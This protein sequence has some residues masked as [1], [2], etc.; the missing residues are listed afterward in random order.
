MIDGRFKHEVELKFV[1]VNAGEYPH[2]SWPKVDESFMGTLSMDP[3][4][5]VD[6]KLVIPALDFD[7]TD[8]HSA[9]IARQ[10]MQ[11]ARI[12]AW[13]E[14]ESAVVREGAIQAQ[15]DDQAWKERGIAINF[16]EYDAY[17]QQSKWHGKHHSKEKH[18]SAHLA[19]RD[20]RA[21]AGYHQQGRHKGPSNRHQPRGGRHKQEE[22][23][24]TSSRAVKADV[25]RQL[26]NLVFE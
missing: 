6:R 23:Q 26:L 13:Q 24:D 15:Q 2:P 14:E 18:H 17:K 3:L 12:Q 20:A 25:G 16:D 5:P 22:K 11:Q 19:A 10:Q 7:V 9:Q 21:N 8:L 1:V 4:N